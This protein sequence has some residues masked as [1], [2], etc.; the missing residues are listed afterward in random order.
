MLYKTICTVLYILHFSKTILLY[1]CTD[2]NVSNINGKIYPRGSGVC[3]HGG[4]GG[5]QNAFDTKGADNCVEML[6]ICSVGRMI[7]KP[8]MALKMTAVV[9]T[10]KMILVLKKWPVWLPPMTALLGMLYE[11]Q[12]SREQ[13][14]LQHPLLQKWTGYNVKLPNPL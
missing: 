8:V 9:C 10:M 4:G 5:I 7:S 1:F 14:I 11:R 12:T 2:V 13:H 6:N 3:V